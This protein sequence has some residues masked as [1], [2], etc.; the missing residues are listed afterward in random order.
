MRKF[1][2]D[3]NCIIAVDERRADA[4]SVLDLAAA[5]FQGRASV[6]V[7]AISA[8]EN[9][10]DGT[11]IEDFGQFS[12]RLETLGLGDLEVLP[13]LAY[14]GFAFFDHCVFASDAQIQRET[15]IHE[16]LFPGIKLDWENYCKERQI[17]KD[18]FPDRKWINM[19]C[20]ALAM[21]SHIAFGRDVFVTADEAFHQKGK[22][23]ALLALGA[24]RIEYPLTAA[25]II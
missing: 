8:S 17:S 23:T 22:K 1:T 5:H 24:G 20:D 16:I 13:T 14:Y 10:K 12:R 6:A 21:W 4:S 9:Q 7:V 2:L 19:R 11:P 3:T 25:R 15:Q 18:D